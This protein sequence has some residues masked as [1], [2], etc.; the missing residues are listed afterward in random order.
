MASTDVHSLRDIQR[1]L[2]DRAALAERFIGARGRRVHVL[3]AGEGHPLV[4]IHGTGNSGLFLLPLVER[5]EGVRA[6]VVDRPGFGLSDPR[7]SSRKH[8]KADA[9]DWID[10]V[11][12][13]LGLDRT[14]L[15]G[16][17]MGG[18]WSVW[19]ACGRPRRVTKLVV[20]GA[21]PG[22]PGTRAPLP[23]R[24]MA[25]PGVGR[26][27]QR[28][29]ATPASVL[30]FAG[31]VGERDALAGQPELL[32]LQVA[33]TNDPVTKNSV[34]TE[35][36]AL[37]PPRALLSPSTFRSPIRVQR[38]D[39]ERIT[40]PTLIVWGDR[41]PVG[42][43]DTA[44]RLSKAIPDSRLEVVPGGHAPWLGEAPRVADI[45]SDFLR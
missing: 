37:I 39:L 32:D 13:E 45:V 29:H 2:A 41:E 42:S 16:H 24:L 14:S 12:D 43:T 30:K 15:L 36:Q 3:E 35:V 19:Y 22:L 6:I 21:A 17:S 25:L 18:L 8:F 5:L 27:L 7:P 1:Q 9:V 31:F 33:S 20:L 38:S 34:R 28:Q 4:M 11:L 23:F 40:A 10:G 44:D 26:L